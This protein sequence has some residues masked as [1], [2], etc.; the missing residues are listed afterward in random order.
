[1]SH[2]RRRQYFDVLN[3]GGWQ[4]PAH[5]PLKSLMND[6]RHDEDPKSIR[7]NIICDS[8]H[9]SWKKSSLD[10]LIRANLV[11]HPERAGFSDELSSSIISEA[12]AG[13]R[14]G[15]THA[16]S[17]L[18]EEANSLLSFSIKVE[19]ITINTISL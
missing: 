6:C 8:D 2:T 4:E 5:D 17:S 11:L 19:V 14:F 13:L 16:F 10:V 1:M 9:V 7:R 15:N 18:V 12:R 3:E